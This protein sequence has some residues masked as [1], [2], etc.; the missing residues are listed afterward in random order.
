MKLF[1]RALAMSAGVS[2]AVERDSGYL[3]TP[4]GVRL[5]YSRVGR[6]T[7]ALIV[8]NGIV[9]AR[10]LEALARGRSVIF[11]DVRNRG[12]SGAVE[13]AGIARGIEHDVDDVETVRRHFGLEQVDLLGH[14]YQGMTTVLY[15]MRYP[16]RVN[17]IVLIAPIAPFP[18]KQYASVAP[19]TTAT[20]VMTKVAAWR[21][22][23][24]TSD[25][26][27]ACREFWAILSPLYVTNAIDAGRIDWGRCDLPNERKAMAYL[28]TRVFPSIAA[29][30]LTETDYARVR[31]PALII[32][33]T[34]DRS[35]P[36]E[37][38]KDWARVLPRARLMTLER[39]GHAPWIEHPKRVA[40]AIHEFLATRPD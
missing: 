5:F 35:V 29:L 1:V 15:A 8:P 16:E 4:D 36:L 2:L 7:R 38:A 27:A 25:E 6:G 20:D 31:R 18:S 34:H 22:Q 17:R 33:G 23:P 13:G 32:H 10:D 28:T 19:D 26:V 37:A 21:A 12:R 3:V 30:G 24:R 39:A 9:Y 40:A 11:F 14:S